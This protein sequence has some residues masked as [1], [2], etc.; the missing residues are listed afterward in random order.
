M[1]RTSQSWFIYWAE[2]HCGATGRIRFCSLEMSGEGFIIHWNMNIYYIWLTGMIVSPV[3]HWSWR[4]GG[5]T[6]FMSTSV[7]PAVHWTIFMSTSVS[8]TVHWT[9]LWYES[10]SP[11]VHWTFIIH[12]VIFRLLL[13]ILVGS[14]VVRLL[15]SYHNA[16]PSRRKRWQNVLESPPDVVPCGCSCGVVRWFRSYYIAKYCVTIFC[17]FSALFKSVWPYSWQHLT[18]ILYIDIWLK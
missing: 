16:P 11:V 4:I 15:F 7:S 14:T 18:T 8:P 10:M 3:V 5:C 13:R 6:I 2:P 1:L 9:I 12:C 17:L